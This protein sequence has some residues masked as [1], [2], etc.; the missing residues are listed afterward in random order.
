MSTVILRAGHANSTLEASD[1][2]IADVNK[3]LPQDRQFAKPSGSGGGPD[4]YVY[5]GQ[6]AG[7]HSCVD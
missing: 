1:E 3:Y 5:K 4:A 7:K 6:R 2:F